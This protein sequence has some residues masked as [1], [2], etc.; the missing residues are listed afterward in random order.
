MKHLIRFSIIALFVTGFNSCSKS[1]PAPTTYP[2]VTFVATLT[3]GSEVP[4]NP[5]TASGTATLSYNP[6][7]KIMALTVNHNIATPTAAHIHKGAS[8]VAGGVIFGFAS[9]VS[10]INYTSVALDAAQEADLYANLYYVN[11][12]TA[13]Y[14]GGEIRGQLIKQ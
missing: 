5:S 4:A 2:Y 9:A 14:P 10:P 3:G 6:S 13:T 8:N 12:H 1:D 11:V 7:T